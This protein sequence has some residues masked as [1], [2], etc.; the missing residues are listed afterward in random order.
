MLCVL[1]TDH[2][3]SHTGP[4]I[5]S[6][7]VHQRLTPEAI[8][9]L[10][11][12]LGLTQAE[13]A[14]RLGVSFAS[15]NRWENG[16]SRP[17]GMAV[18]QLERLRAELSPS[19]PSGPQHVSVP[20]LDF[21]GDPPRVAAVAEAERL[22]LGHL[23]N[24]AFAAELALIDPLPH[25]RLAVY[26]R[27]LP[28]PRLRFLLADDAG[29]GKTIMAGLY[30][31]EM[32]GRGL[33]RR[34]LVVSPA[35]LIGNWASELRKLFSL[36][37]TII[38]GPDAR[39]GNPFAGAGGSLAIVSIDTLAGDRM[40]T[41]LQE[42]GTEP[43][44][45]VIMDEAHKL[46]VDREQ[47]FRLR[48]TDR[49]RVAESLAGVTTDDP[50][51]E[52]G[53]SANHLLLMTATPHMGKDFPYFGLW[54][55]LEPDV[56][57]T[58]DAFNAYPPDAR[59][60]HFLRRTKEEMVRFDGSPI[61][62][63][64]VSNTLSYDLSAGGDVSEQ[65]LYDETTT[66]IRDYYN[67]ARVLNRS[68]AQLAMSVFQR[69]LASS[70][71]ALLR[72]FERRA[73]KLDELITAI[74]SGGM[75]SED[76]PGQ[77][78]RLEAVRDLLDETTADEESFQDG[79]EEHERSEDDAL[80]GTAASSI[81]EVRD[82]RNRVAALADLAR[83]VYKLEEESK[84]A[85]LREVIRDPEY[86]DEK[87]IIFTEHR[88][89][90]EF[91]VRRLEGL[92]FAG[93]IA[94]I[95]GGMDHLRR[96]EQIEFFR[97]PAEVGGAT[98]LVATDAAGEGVNLQFCRLMVNYDIPWNPARLEQRMGRIHRYGQK[99]DP[100]VIINLVAGKTR[101]GHVLH[102][103]L[104]K[105]ERIRKELGNDK[106]FDVVGRLFHGVSLKEYMLQALTPEGAA[107]VERRL[108]GTLT[109]AQVQAIAAQER[110]LYGDGGDVRSALVR[111]RPE[112]EAEAYRRLLPG[113]ER[114]FLQNV[115]PLLRLGIDGD[116]DGE[117]SVHALEP[118]AL[119][120][121][122]P[123]LEAYRP[124]QRFRL[125]VHKP[126][127]PSAEDVVFLHPGEPVFDRV[128]DLVSSRFEQ[129]A[130]RGGLFTD[131]SA[132]APYLLHVALI[133][134]VRRDAARSTQVP[135]DI[136]LVVIRDDGSGSMEQRAPEELLLL[137]PAVGRHPVSPLTATAQE[138]V[139][140]AAGFLQE[141]V[142]APLAD[143]RRKVLADSLPEREAF[144]RR[145]YD[146]QEADLAAARVKL[147]ERASAGDPR[148]QTDLERVRDRQRSLEE[149]R[150]RAIETLR[151]E[152]ER[153]APGPVDFI[154]HA[155]VLPSQSTEEARQRDAEIERIAVDFVRQ[156]EFAAGA[157]DVKDVS[158]PDGARAAG[159]PDRPGFD[160]LAVH[161]DAERRCI[162]V[163]GRAAIGDIEVTENEW[164]RSANLRQEY[165]LY[166]VFD[167]ASAHP[168]LVRV[169]DPF[170]A[171]LVRAKGGV[172]IDEAAVFASAEVEP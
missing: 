91:L 53:W 101:E 122:W 99:H 19:T 124:E 22:R 88:D 23:M 25:Q 76:L 127:G 170:A 172:V 145:G 115:A 148:A 152:V 71:W 14:A 48:K 68:A 26:E 133:R 90:L 63:R 157:I 140:R 10:R 46:S 95:H 35:G 155:L 59:S 11:E 89:T 34:V 54:R 7:L 166:V 16:Q 36:S 117:F 139:D 112:L 8:R 102:T 84:L 132:N 18:A 3:I 40:F 108:E 15:V 146:Y 111:L 107:E 75:R 126:E 125:T 39:A 66:Y 154:A 137:K 81:L 93:Q 150:V 80:G 12:R 79:A 103:L 149:R 131:S 116:P 65:R 82:E 92:G 1:G 143:E 141:R 70:T 110:A 50:R 162:E 42:P 97:R 20:T 142:L 74:E 73:A 114:R 29:A 161:Q 9:S 17:S 94:T 134:V 62:P 130:R 78:R 57:P 147:R 151:D 61:Y 43:Y 32:L 167:C 52:L 51:W 28:Q 118:G 30:I 85:K 119:D 67:R 44:D 100:V 47:D 33:L 113:Y 13:L 153:V 5:P 64:R 98:Y 72:S 45:L 41:R 109:P 168:R 135:D 105:L 58:P 121:L 144:V 163:K 2:A 158:L 129:D 37:F 159:L 27:M 106:V 38:T 136:R 6:R 77:Q 4:V 123:V 69:R 138:S 55:L 31:R 169:R 164:A 49:Y 165:W 60:R 171:L 21:L 83:R 128:L 104:L 87:L 120:S 156:Y 160:L 96:Q 86:R 56:L 24:P